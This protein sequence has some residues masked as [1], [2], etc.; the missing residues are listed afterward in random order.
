MAFN[1]SI[2][3]PPHLKKW[4]WATIAAL[5]IG[6]IIGYLFSSGTG[7]AAHQ[8][9]VNLTT[10]GGQS[11]SDNQKLLEDEKSNYTIVIGGIILLVAL[12]TYGYYKE[13]QKK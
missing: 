4:A 13:K 2:K 5:V 6:F 3:L 1:L 10:G 12:V 11:Q 9:T 8:R 7:P